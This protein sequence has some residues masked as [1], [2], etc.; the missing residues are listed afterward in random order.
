MPGARLNVWQRVSACLLLAAV[1]GQPLLAQDSAA[2]PARLTVDAGDT[3]TALA[4]QM[5]PEGATLEQ[6]LVALWRAN[7]RAFGNGNL[8]QLLQGA[9]LKVPSAQDILR[10]P[11]A[12]A[13]ALVLEQVEHFQS[14]VR[15]QG[16]GATA[17]AASANPSAESAALA[18]ALAEAQALKEAL[19]R[20]SRD[21]QA[22]LAQL[23]KNIQAL[24][25]LKPAAAATPQAPAPAAEP[26]ASEPAAAASDAAAPQASGSEAASEP[27]APALVAAPAQAA[28]PEAALPMPLLT[29]AGGALLVLVLLVWLLTRQRKAP[30]PAPEIPT[31]I[32]PPMA[33]ISLDLGSPPSLPAAPQDPRP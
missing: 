6:T 22:Q 10:I 3:A 13:H 5:R 9:T 19:E 4:L 16:K 12:Q 8:N 21:T 31:K 17:T 15:Q 27:V 14:Y 23:E 26:A 24:Q 30:A 18:R 7:P 28:Q 2:P 1:C 20:Q 32:P 33:S 11:A 25:S 29:W